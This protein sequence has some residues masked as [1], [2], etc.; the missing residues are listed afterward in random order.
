MGRRAIYFTAEEKKQAKTKCMLKK[1]WR[2]HV[3][4]NHNYTLAGK[5]N[6]LKS[7]K[8]KGN[9]RVFKCHEKCCYQKIDF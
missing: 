8:H 7:Q 4:N 9:E 5:W 2:C 3:C 6:H 1:E